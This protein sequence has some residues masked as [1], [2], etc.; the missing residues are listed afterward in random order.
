MRI[1]N[2]ILNSISSEKL[3]SVNKKLDEMVTEV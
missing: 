3:Y 2:K 1:G